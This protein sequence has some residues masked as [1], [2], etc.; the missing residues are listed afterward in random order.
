MNDPF[1]S[2]GFR[3]S[4]PDGDDRERLVCDDCGWINYV[5]PKIIVGVVA[6]WEDKILLGRRAIEP[7]LG[8]WGLPAGFMEE[9]ETPEQGAIREAAEET[10]AEI[11]LNALLGIYSIPRISHVQLIYRGTLTSPD[12][13]CGPEC[14]DV[15]LFEWEDIPWEELAFTTV[16][17]ALKHY[18]ETRHLTDFQPRTVDP[19]LLD[20][21]Q[22][23]TPPE[24]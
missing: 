14:L 22:K 23:P 4:I 12:I 19:E 21:R 3:P 5:N 10:R 15:G 20:H 2:Y 17:W 9:G 16:H 13:S 7:R 6:T 1:S 24:E 8:F 11:T 18:H